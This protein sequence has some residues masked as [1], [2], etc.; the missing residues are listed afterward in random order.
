MIREPEASLRVRYVVWGK[1]VTH[2]GRP[3]GRC[4]GVQIVISVFRALG[5]ALGYSM[6]KAKALPSGQERRKQ[7]SYSHRSHSHA[8]RQP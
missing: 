5:R 1:T 2:D 7:E 3:G 4:V 6:N 8:P